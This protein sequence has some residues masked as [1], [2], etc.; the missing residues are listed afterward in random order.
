M[1]TAV[2]STSYSPE[3][4]ELV[5]GLLREQVS[6]YDELAGYADEQRAVIAEEDTARLLS[7]L[8][9]RQQL[10][11][12]LSDM[13][14]RLE[15][16]RKNWDRFRASFNQVQRKEAEGLLGKIRTRLRKL[17]E[18]D[19]EDVQLLSSRKQMAAVAMQSTASTHRAMSAYRTADVRPRR[20]D[21]MDEGT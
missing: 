20:L 4:P 19:E 2:P 11:G 13:V 12:R 8:G 1:I 6:L 3:Q 7:V 15:P 21:Q 5:L 14:E 9:K 10:S 17:I 16:I 18:R